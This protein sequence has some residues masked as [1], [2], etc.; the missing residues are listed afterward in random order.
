[1]SSE[2]FFTEDLLIKTQSSMNILKRPLLS[3]INDHVVDY[4]TPINIHYA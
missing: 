2:L 4:P 3:A 1:V